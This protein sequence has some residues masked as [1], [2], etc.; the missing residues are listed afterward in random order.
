MLAHMNAKAIMWYYKNVIESSSDEESDG[1]T[2][3]LLAAAMHHEQLLA[4]PRRH[5]PLEKREGKGEGR[6]EGHVRLLEDYFQDEPTFTDKDCCRGFGCPEGCS[7][8]SK[9]V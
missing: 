2:D 4:L 6:V 3:I 9:K 1:D 8:R 7:W 5:V